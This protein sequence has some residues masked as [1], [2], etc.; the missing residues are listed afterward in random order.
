[1]K[2]SVET[3]QISISISDAVFADALCSRTTILSDQKLLPTSLRLDMYRFAY[4][5]HE[6]GPHR[7]PI[8]PGLSLLRLSQIKLGGRS[9]WKCVLDGAIIFDRG[10]GPESM[11]FNV[12]PITG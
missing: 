2:N 9:I 3:V 4:D 12:I 1:M 10:C 6:W 5:A 7:V 8:Y 11:S